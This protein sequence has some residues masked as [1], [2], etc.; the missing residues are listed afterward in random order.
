MK[1]AGTNVPHG[2]GY[3]RAMRK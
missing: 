2:K 3:N 1:E